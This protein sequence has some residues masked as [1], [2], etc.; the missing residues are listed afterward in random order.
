MK[1][2]DAPN[3][4]LHSL[5]AEEE[6]R[7]I[8]GE[9]VDRDSY[10]RN[11][12]LFSV[13]SAGTIIWALLDMFNEAPASGLVTA[14]GWLLWFAPVAFCVPFAHV[15]ASHRRDLIRAGAY[16]QVFFEEGIGRRGWQTRKTTFMTQMK[17]E[18]ND[19]MFAFY[20]GLL[21]AST[22][23][24]GTAE[25]GLAEFR[26]LVP[27]TLFLLILW[28]SR[29]FNEAVATYRTSCILMWRHIRDEEKS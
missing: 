14:L 1:A 8:R 19:F 10:M 27:I 12:F 4:E 13:T 15:I 28:A 3:T 24:S 23:L 25:G 9:L 16:I 22:V 7:Q 18:S 2:D 20:F 26:P 6:Y 29:R 17:G 5:L 11:V 21:F